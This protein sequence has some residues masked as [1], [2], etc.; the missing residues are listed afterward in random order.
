VMETTFEINGK[1]FEAY[2]SV[3]GMKMKDY[4]NLTEA[5]RSFSGMMMGKKVDIKSDSDDDM[6]TVAEMV[7]G[8]IR[9]SG[10]DPLLSIVA[11]IFRCEDYDFHA[12]FKLLEEASVDT[13]EKMMNVF[14][15]NFFMDLKKKGG[16]LLAE[17]GR[18][19][20]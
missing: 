13:I 3:N 12:R 17:L 6:I 7:N 1:M 14:F 5:Y 15:C 19:N 18:E 10:S 2:P 9:A 11:S 8:I 20:R 16:N 4:M